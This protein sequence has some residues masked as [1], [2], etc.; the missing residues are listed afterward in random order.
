MGRD[1]KNEQR[2]GH[3]AQLHRP[4]MQ[5]P[6]WRALSTTAQALFPWL[7]LE[8]KGPDHNN[9]GSIQLSV[10]QA[11]ERMG[12]SLNTAASAFH[13][14][15]AKGFIVVTEPGRLGVT[16][17]AKGPKYEITTL[18]PRYSEKRG[19]RELYREWE[20]GCDF[21][22]TKARANNPSGRNGKTKPHHQNEDR[23]VIKM[24]T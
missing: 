10:R 24:K 23:N 3:F 18:A 1:R 21:P 7:L 15:Q 13:D 17:Q 5:T 6:A 14:L 20:E 8:W 11:A 19:G 22:V 12:V 16:G 2:K 4:M 9:N